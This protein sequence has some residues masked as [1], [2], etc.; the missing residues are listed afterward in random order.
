MLTIALIRASLPSYFPLRHGVWAG[1]EAVLAR[2]CEA[3]GARLHVVPVTPMNAADTLLALEA[4]RR[5]A[6][7]FVLCLHGG[8]TMG[9]VARTIAA[10]EFRA[11][12]W[13][14]PEPIRTGDIQLNNFEIG[15]AHV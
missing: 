9:D 8:F 2:L 1:A 10:S 12:F 7:D 4:C 15:R 14:V 3:Q 5:E 6:A 13:S 11:G